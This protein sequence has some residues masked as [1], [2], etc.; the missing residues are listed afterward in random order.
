MIE[1][2]KDIIVYDD[3]QSAAEGGPEG[4]ASRFQSAYLNLDDY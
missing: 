4:E 3:G 1:N 2:T